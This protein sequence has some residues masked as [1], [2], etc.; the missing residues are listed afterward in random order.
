M[1]KNEYKNWMNSK[2]QKK[3]ALSKRKLLKPTIR[4]YI[5]LAITVVDG[6]SQTT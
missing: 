6:S 5:P 2:G 1:S 4:R 3:N